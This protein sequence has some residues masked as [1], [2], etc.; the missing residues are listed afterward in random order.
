MFHIGACEMRC[1]E[2]FSISG[3]LVGNKG[4]AISLEKSAI[5]DPF[6]TG[7]VETLFVFN[8]S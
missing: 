1:F 8:K 6:G 4:H 3:C 2:F 5:L 7:N